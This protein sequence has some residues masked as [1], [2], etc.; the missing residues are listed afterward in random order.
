LP[1]TLV[2]HPDF[3][4]PPSSNPYWARLKNFPE[5][6][7]CDHTA[8][9]NPG[10][11]RD[12][13]LKKFSSSPELHVEI[14]C[15]AGHVLIEW[16]TQNPNKAYIGIDWKFKAIHRGAEKAKKRTL[17]NLIFLR[18][19]AERM[20]FIFGP[21]EIDQ[22]H[23]YFPDPWPKRAHWTNRL[24]TAPQ[25]LIFSKF[26]KS[27][28]QLEIKT[29]HIDY[30][31]WMQRQIQEVRHAWRVIEMTED[32]HAGH[33]KPASLDIPEVTLFEKVFIRENIKIH[34]IRLLRV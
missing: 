33:P 8:E 5:C 26:I 30:F 11:W 24:V 7:Y 12:R 23:L 3:R 34:R 14:G 32:L 19:H 29:D 31:N 27:G 20:P 17:E 16:A 6:A 18:A 4:Y 1:L 13:F 10:K 15:N 28:G 21:S 9:L 25:L 2:S 22:L